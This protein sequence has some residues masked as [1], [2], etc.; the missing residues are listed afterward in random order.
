MT[1]IFVPLSSLDETKH[2]PHGPS[3]TLSAPVSLNLQAQA[4][5]PAPLADSLLARRAQ[6]WSLPDCAVVRT[7]EA[8]M[9]L[10]KSIRTLQNWRHRRTGPAYQL[11][12][13]VTYR[14][15]DLRDYVD[16]MTT[17]TLNQAKYA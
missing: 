11:G 8:A 4:P 12:K 3:L 13:I 6:L 16:G 15:G 1:Q 2:A 7:Q 9:M 14:V 5:S 17:S 10:S